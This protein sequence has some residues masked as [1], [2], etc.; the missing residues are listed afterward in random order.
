MLVS[1]SN[2]SLITY[3][4]LHTDHQ[5]RNLFFEE[6]CTDTILYI[7]PYK[8]VSESFVGGVVLEVIRLVFGEEGFKVSKAKLINEES[9]CE[10][11]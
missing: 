1:Q 11:R 8:T 3:I 10:V 6:K 9:H 4:S 5:V 2:Y 7:Y